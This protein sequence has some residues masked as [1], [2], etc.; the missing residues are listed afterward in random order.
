MLIR[1]LFFLISIFLYTLFFRHLIKKYSNSNF[2][3]WKPI[4]SFY[5]ARL[6]LGLLIT[7]ITAITLVTG[8]FIFYISTA[9]SAL[10]V[11]KILPFARE[12]LTPIVFLSLALFYLISQIF[13]CIFIHKIIGK[14][15]GDFVVVL[16]HNDGRRLFKL[17]IK[18][19][20]MILGNFLFRNVYFIFIMLPPILTIPTIKGLGLMNAPDITFAVVFASFYIPASMLVS[21]FISFSH[22]YSNFTLKTVKIR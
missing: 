5:I 2:T 15:F 13:S 22:K 18:T 14:H 9:P 1:V 6:S 12:N 11:D 8:F 4:L 19:S 21:L 3:N 10:I 7:A 20:A 17:D 16:D